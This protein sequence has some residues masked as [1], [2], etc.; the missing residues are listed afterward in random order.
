MKKVFN[1]GKGI[2]T[3]GSSRGFCGLRNATMGA[4]GRFWN[5]L[6]WVGGVLYLGIWLSDAGSWDLGLGGT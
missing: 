3:L 6:C 4:V 5:A 1:T 2:S